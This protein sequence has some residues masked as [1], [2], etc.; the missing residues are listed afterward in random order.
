[1]TCRRCVY[2]DGHNRCTYDVSNIKLPMSTDVPIPVRKHHV[3]LRSGRGCVCFEDRL[4]TSDPCEYNPDQ[5]RA[6]YDNEVHA[7]AEF[8][9]GSNGKWRLCASCASL[10][11][12]KKYSVRRRIIND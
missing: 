8:I 3:T 10:P 4:T 1:M 11:E 7:Q 12:F 5:K 9:V 2:F 6:A